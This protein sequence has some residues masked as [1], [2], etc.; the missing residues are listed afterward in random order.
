MCILHIEMCTHRHVFILADSWLKNQKFRS[1]HHEQ[2]VHWWWSHWSKKEKTYKLKTYK[3]QAFKNHLSNIHWFHSPFPN[4]F[5][6]YFFW[7]LN[8]C[9]WAKHEHIIKN[10]WKLTWV[11]SAR[12]IMNSDNWWSLYRTRIFRG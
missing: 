8:P 11:K 6:G 7:D 4:M 12:F 9:L 2:K 10:N 1:S 3:H 5:S